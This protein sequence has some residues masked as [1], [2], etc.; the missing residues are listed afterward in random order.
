MCTWKAAVSGSRTYTVGT[1][2]IDDRPDVTLEDI[3]YHFDVAMKV[4]EAEAAVARG[5]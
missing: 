5:D 3:Q 4:R 2:S 1:P